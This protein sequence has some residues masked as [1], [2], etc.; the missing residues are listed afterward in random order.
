MI[1]KAFQSNHD[2]YKYKNNPEE[3]AQFI[4]AEKAKKKQ[5]YF[6]PFCGVSLYMKYSVNDIPFFSCFPNKPHTSP[7][8]K[9]LAHRK[10]AIDTDVPAFDL[11]R[12][13]HILL[14]PETEHPKRPGPHHIGP[15][16]FPPEEVISTE[17]TDPDDNPDPYTETGDPIDNEDEL[18]S[19]EIDQ[20]D[21]SVQIIPPKS[22]RDIL[23]LGCNRMPG[24]EI[25]NSNSR[26]RAIDLI[27]AIP[28]LE[29]LI[30]NPM[31]LNGSNRIVEMR[32]I[33]I[34]NNRTIICQAFQKFSNEYKHIYFYLF[35][36][37]S[38]QYDS[39]VN[40][41]FKKDED[42]KSRT[43]IKPKH[44]SIYVCGTWILSSNPHVYKGEASPRFDTYI[45][46]SRKQLYCSS[47]DKF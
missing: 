27:I 15:E 20:D 25:I 3:T 18:N 45:V 44:K 32:A 41:L 29:S 34:R 33:T 14:Q 23:E 37:T 24:N 19:E 47:E 12:F 11:D 40:K 39:L 30:S 38:R 28:S 17:E 46:N 42:E 21:C 5:E 26:I 7:V 4:R 6:C 1:I 36:T 35:C 2:F 43:I 16:D 9:R 8:C 13:F 22:I 10:E 31:M